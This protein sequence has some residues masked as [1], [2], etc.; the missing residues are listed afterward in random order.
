[1]RFVCSATSCSA[2]RRASR[3]DDCGDVVATHRQVHVGNVTLVKRGILHAEEEILAARDPPHLGLVH[4]L[5]I[6]VAVEDFDDVLVARD[7]RRSGIRIGCDELLRQHKIGQ[8][9]AQQAQADA[10]HARI[11]SAATAFAFRPSPLAAKIAG[12]I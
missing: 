10:M 11:L 9:S 6:R 12:A 2:K 4:D 8:E 7:D 3:L 5:K 1:M